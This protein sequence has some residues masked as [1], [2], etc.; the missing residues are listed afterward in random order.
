MTDANPHTPPDFA[1]MVGMLVHDRGPDGLT[2]ISIGRTVEGHWVIRTAIEP[3]GSHPDVTYG[4]GWSDWRYPTA[5]EAL[6][7]ALAITGHLRAVAGHAN[8]MTCA[9]CDRPARQTVDGTRYC[10]T[11]DESAAAIAEWQASCDYVVANDPL[12]ALLVDPI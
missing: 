12:G 9:G 8:R 6:A 3:D 10:G 5:G 2:P 11:C 4:N 1:H 7:R